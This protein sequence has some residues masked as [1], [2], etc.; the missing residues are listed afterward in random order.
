MYFYANSN[1]F[2]FWYWGEMTQAFLFHEIHEA[3]GTITARNVAK[4]QMKRVQNS[5]QRSQWI[6]KERE[7]RDQSLICA[8][9]DANFALALCGRP[10]RVTKSKGR[11][12]CYQWQ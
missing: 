5:G 9:R 4:P 7:K 8:Q 11:K 1:T 10:V 3:V 6:L 2:T 12:Q